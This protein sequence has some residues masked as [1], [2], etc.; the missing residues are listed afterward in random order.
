M[1][2]L[3]DLKVGFLTIKL[4]EPKIGL[5]F[6]EEKNTFI[7]IYEINKIDQTVRFRNVHSEKEYLYQIDNINLFTLVI[8]Y[9]N[10]DYDLHKSQWQINR[11]NLNGKVPF[12]FKGDGPVRVWNLTLKQQAELLKRYNEALEYYLK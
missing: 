1:I 10:K 11:K 8:N 7:E 5:M 4:S 2:N 6:F 9:Q 12:I 3:N